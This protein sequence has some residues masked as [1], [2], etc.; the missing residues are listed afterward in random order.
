[1]QLFVGRVTNVGSGSGDSALSVWVNPDNLLDLDE[2]AAATASLANRQVEAITQFAFVKGANHTGFFDELRV[3]GSFDSVAPIPEP[4]TWA[5]WG[6]L[7]S[8]G[9]LAWRRRRQG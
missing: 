5:L 6:G 4:A 7:L 3:G 9:A 2:G 1:G 8:L